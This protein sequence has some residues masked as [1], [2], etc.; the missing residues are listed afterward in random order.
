MTASGLV[1]EP[2]MT[3]PS[4]NPDPITI[5][6]IRGRL[7]RRLLVWV[8]ASIS[9]NLVWWA[10]GIDLAW[11]WRVLLV[12]ASVAG[13]LWISLRPGRHQAPPVTARMKRLSYGVELLL[14]SGVAAL[15]NV[16]WWIW[17]GFDLAAG[18][19]GVRWVVYVVD[20][21]VGIG[22]IAALAFGGFLRVALS[23]R[24]V[25][26]TTKVALALLWWCP[27][28]TAILLRRVTRALDQE[29]AVGAARAARDLD[30]ADKQ[31][32]R[33]RYPLLM[34]HGIFFRDWPVFNYWGRIPDGLI[35]NGAT[36][37]YGGQQSSASVARSAEELADTIRRIVDETGCGKV[38]IIAHSKGGLDAR[39]AI[40]QL[41]IADEVASLTTINTPH[42]GCNFARQLMDKIPDQMIGRISE[43]YDAVFTKLGDPSPDFLAGVCDLTDTECAR[44][45]ALMPDWPAVVYQSVGSVMVSRFA[46]PFPLNLGYSLIQP[47][48]GDNDGLVA[49]SSMAW[50]DFLGVF[51]PT[52][53]NGISHADM[54]DVL[55]RDVGDFDVVEAYVQMVSDLRRRGL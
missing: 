34:V 8:V 14:A 53:A 29:I 33:T 20:I 24:Q 2:A 47:V 39:W 3:A 6:P 40:S 31:I 4:L 12:L 13:Y 44:L 10:A 18:P 55:R 41:G 9:V 50:G 32:C 48:D 45:N 46:S 52:G 22:L 15:A 21:V 19:Q 35:A 30:R 42:R 23:S 28:L 26:V 16:A 51:R 1:T 49:L 36:I 5:S 7:P 54:I 38:N 27:P 25:T 17:L 37:H 43:R 11:P